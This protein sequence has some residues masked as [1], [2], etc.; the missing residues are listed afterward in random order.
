[1]GR[2][3]QNQLIDAVSVAV[4]VAAPILQG[5]KGDGQGDLGQDISEGWKNF[6]QTMGPGKETKHNINEA[7]FAPIAAPQMGAGTKASTVALPGKMTGATI[8]TGGASM[9]PAQMQLMQ[10]GQFRDQQMT[11]AQQLAAQASGQGPSL[12]TEQLKQAQAANQA[13]IFAQM[14]SQR[15]GANPGMA[16]QAMQTSAQIQGQTARDA[17]LA[18]IQE[19]MG[20]REQLG[21]VLNTGRAGDIDI[22]K[23]QAGLE[24]EAKLAE[25]KAKIDVAVQQGQLDQ[26]TANSIYQAEV[27]KGMKDAELASQFQA[28]QAEYM[29]KGLDAQIAT[30]MAAIELEKLKLD[31]K[32]LPRQPGV[33]GVIGSIIGG[34]T[35]AGGGGGSK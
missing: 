3:Q 22:A 29:A 5:A 28:L 35:A 34:Y 12:A 16:R 2:K 8:N 19:Q 30:Q 33:A 24:Q 20:A 25:F 27:G 14:A 11:L 31:V 10:Q 7:A 23:S 1:M 6:A 15:G 18:R 13:A 4:P 17:A 26:Q 32:T 21:A 9:T